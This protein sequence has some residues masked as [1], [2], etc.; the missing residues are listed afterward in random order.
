M[1]VCMCIFMYLSSSSH[2]ILEYLGLAQTMI[3]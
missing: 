3:H 1:Y 2:L